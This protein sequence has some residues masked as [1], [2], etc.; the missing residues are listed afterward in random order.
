[1]HSPPRDPAASVDPKTL[2]AAVDHAVRQLGPP[3]GLKA[4]RV[5]FVFV[6]ESRSVFAF[7][8]PTIAERSSS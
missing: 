2:A 4:V 3:P 7:P 8:V 5:S 6:D 1:M